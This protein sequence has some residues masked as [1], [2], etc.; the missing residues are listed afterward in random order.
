MLTTRPP[1][2]WNSW[3]TF[4]KDINEDLICDTADAI[5]KN[6]LDKSGYKYVVID[7]CWSEKERDKNGNLVADHIKFPH[8]MKYVGDYVH[9]KGLKFGMYTDSGPKTCAG[10]PGSYGHE[11]EDARFFA[12]CGVDYLKYDNCF[13]P[14]QD[15]NK[16]YNRMAMALKQTKRHIVFSACSWGTG[17][18]HDW[19]RSCGVDLYRSTGDI[20]DNFDSVKNILRSQMDKFSKTGVGCYNDMDMLI[21]GLKG[22]GNI[23]KNQ[24]CTDAQY[25]YHF[26]AWCM[27]GSPLMIGCDV[28]NITDENLALLKQENL[29]RIDQDSECRPPIFIDDNRGHKDNVIM[30][31]HLDDNTYAIGLFNSYDTKSQIMFQFYEIGIDPLSGYAFD[32]TDAF[33]NEH[34][35]IARDYID[36]EVDAGDCK[37]YLAKLVKVR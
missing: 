36:P 14:S 32:L 31:K 18:V 2:G 20:F 19:A 13:H 34:I 4:T 16:R 28:R 24:G 37:V 8:G 25:R 1:M 27:C 12:K 35:G 21:T 33:T 6:G 17:G 26:A 11:F 9:S 7:D 29:I 30:F 15:T 22:N 3:N 10:Y 5:V 23:S